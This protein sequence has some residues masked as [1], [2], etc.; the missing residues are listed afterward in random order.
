MNR[1]E[2][3]LAAG[4]D[5]ELDPWAAPEA[6]P[7]S[8]SAL[9]ITSTTHQATTAPVFL[10]SASY[11]SQQ[12]WGQRGCE[13]SSNMAQPLQ[14]CVYMIGVQRQRN[15]LPARNHNTDMPACIRFSLAEQCNDKQQQLHLHGYYSVFHSSKMKQARLKLIIH[16]MSL[17]YISKI[18][19]LN[20]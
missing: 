5:I 11:H 6:I 10:C 13:C 2:A 19:I 18:S 1:G 9:P 16:H 14:E 8:V 15:K 20:I 12:P 3:R 17:K 7:H 4:L